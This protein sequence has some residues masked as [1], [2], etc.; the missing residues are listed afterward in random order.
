MDHPGNLFQT[1]PLLAEKV[2][3][4]VLE[5][6]EL[7]EDYSEEQNDDT[8]DD[9]TLAGIRIGR[10]PAPEEPLQHYFVPTDSNNDSN[11]DSKVERESYRRNPTLLCS[12]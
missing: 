11:T 5:H 9:P 4:N 10:I 12:K 7:I 6:E 1:I 2:T 8:E 3:V